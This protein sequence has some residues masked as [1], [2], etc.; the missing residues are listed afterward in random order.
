MTYRCQSSRRKRDIDSR[1]GQRF[2]RPRPFGVQQFFFLLRIFPRCS[3]LRCGDL[4]HESL[5]LHLELLG[6]PD[7]EKQERLESLGQTRPGK[8]VS[9]YEN[10][11]LISQNGLPDVALDIRFLDQRSHSDTSMSEFERLQFL[12]QEETTVDHAQRYGCPLH[13]RSWGMYDINRPK[14]PS[15]YKAFPMSA[16]SDEN[17]ARF[18]NETFRSCGDTDDM[19]ESVESDVQATRTCRSAQRRYYRPSDD[20]LNGYHCQISYLL[21]LT[22]FHCECRYT[23]ALAMRQKRMSQLISYPRSFTICGRITFQQ[24]HSEP[25]HGLF[26]RSESEAGNTTSCVVREGGAKLQAIFTHLIG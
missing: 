9:K 16:T 22:V 4:G 8:Y 18:P 19:Q 21:P 23:H 17:N 13:F 2:A 14:L 7:A 15:P 20:K 26:I 12:A 25:N 24:V 10:R 3:R 5:Q 1:L 6:L 11:S